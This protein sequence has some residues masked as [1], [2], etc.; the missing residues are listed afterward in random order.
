MES[1]TARFVSS[2]KVGPEIDPLREG[3]P[4][5]PSLKPVAQR[6]GSQPIVDEDE[7][8]EEGSED[9]S[10]KSAIDTNLPVLLL[11]PTS[12]TRV[13]WDFFILALLL[14]VFA[15]VPLGMAFGERFE[16]PFYVYDLV[17]DSVFLFDILLNFRTAYR[18][19]PDVAYLETNQWKVAW[20]YF[21]TWF[22]ID[23]ISCPSVLMLALESDG[24]AS[25]FT[26]FKLLKGA[27]TL[28][29]LKVVKV[30][31]LLRVTKMM[32]KYADALEE[33]MMR[34]STQVRFRMIQLLA[35]VTF[36][37]HIFACMWIT[38]SNSTPGTQ[39]WMWKYSD[40]DDMDDA[41]PFAKWDMGDQ[42]VA[43]FYFAITTMSSV[44]Y[45]D[46]CPSST[47]ERLYM[48]L[49]MTVGGGIYGFII[50]SLA[51]VVTTLDTNQK[52][53]YERME[54]I[55]SY[56]TIREFPPALRSRTHRYFRKFFENHT[57][58]DEQAILNDLPPRLRNDVLRLLVNGAVRESYLFRD[59]SDSAVAKLALIFK[60]PE[61]ESDHGPIVERGEPGDSMFIITN[62]A[63]LCFR[64][65]R[66]DDPPFKRSSL[67]E[68]RKS[69]LDFDLARL[70]PQKRI[71]IGTGNA[72]HSATSGG[73]GHSFE[74]YNDEEETV[75]HC[76]LEEGDA[77]GELV[78]LG[79]ENCYNATIVAFNHGPLL[80]VL[81]ATR[82]DLQGYIGD[83]ED[84]PELRRRAA[85]HS[86]APPPLAVT[87][88][89]NASWALKQEASRQKA[90]RA[91]QEQNSAAKANGSGLGAFD[92]TSLA[93]TMSLDDPFLSV[94]GHRSS[95]SASSPV[96]KMA[97]TPPTPAAPRALSKSHSEPRIG[98]ADARRLSARCKGRVG[99]AESNLLDGELSPDSQ[100]HLRRN[101]IMK[102]LASS[103]RSGGG[104]HS[105]QDTPL[106]GVDPPPSSV[107]G[108]L[109][110]LQRSVADL[111]DGQ[112]LANQRQAIVH[113]RLH[114]LEGLFEGIE[115]SLRN[116]SMAVRIS[117]APAVADDSDNQQFRVQQQTGRGLAGLFGNSD[118]SSDAGSEILDTETLPAT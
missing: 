7:F 75:L 25:E 45:G 69:V 41:K 95:S 4:G 110:A 117:G 16:K 10:R 15:T 82:E 18:P 101:S 108:A 60:T 90:K 39:S 9:D 67:L 13:S 51:S 94:G 20:K 113:E 118:I 99:S 40:M 28:K 27:K 36:S 97:K 78:G 17:I 63:A 87:G 116:L 106:G 11:L 38:V 21:S 70:S 34:G 33:F 105:G 19:S 103:A 43:A 86:R 74:Q 44:G 54:M 61:F 5:T 12:P 109:E 50:A 59:L 91:K 58:L 55:H 14:I 48:I 85:A 68:H 100:V 80:E 35:L 104:L 26:I 72:G 32:E 93:A 102:P 56:M 2:N 62:G 53:Y 52:S 29:V 114:N 22:F 81:F 66:P 37:A 107:A 71:S 77:F 1:R 83:T 8:D 98:D 31:K 89:L 23:L 46:I 57:A 79:L 112:E 6:P 115:E 84:W 30:L 42:Y 73:A 47:S 64:D 3:E 49:A 111:A 92:P 96:V 76:V 65:R 24:I 88:N